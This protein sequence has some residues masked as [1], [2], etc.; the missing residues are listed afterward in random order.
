MR[1]ERE[2]P[3]PRRR[4]RVDMDELESAFDNASHELR[5]Y[6]DL[7][8]GDVVMVTDEARREVVA[9]DEEIYGDGDEPCVPFAGA[10]AQRDLPDWM[11]EAVAEAERV[12]D[13][14]GTR[15][16]AVTE[17][18]SRWGYRVMDDF[19]DT[20]PDARLRDRL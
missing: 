6:L 18:D 14:D 5:Y 9:L 16:I 20:V 1:H 2:E 8:T 13:G 12:E 11:K 10:L 4:L 15:Y 3:R 19:I 17:G 7:E